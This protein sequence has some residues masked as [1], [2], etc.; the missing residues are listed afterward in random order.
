MKFSIITPTYN[1]IDT[2][3]RAIKSIINQTYQNY[4]MIIVDDGSNDRTEE[5]VKKY[6][7]SKIKY[8]KLNKNSGVNKA[9]NI[10]LNN[11]SKDC[12]F[13]TFL[14]SDDTFLEGALD[15]MRRN[16]LKHQNH[17]VYGFAV[18]D[19]NGNNYSF[20]DNSEKS[21]TYQELL[22]NII[23]KGEWVYCMGTDLIFNKIFEYEEKVKNG[24]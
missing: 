9:R 14:D 19:H 23:V 13:V 17:K 20:L 15:T 12:D 18:K 24:A 1:N 11:I 22:C 8:I 2:I 21:I 10:G 5:I 16:I 6:L 4:E 7:T 3:E